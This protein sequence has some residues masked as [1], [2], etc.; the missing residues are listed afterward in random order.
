MYQPNTDFPFRTFMT[1]TQSNVRLPFLPIQQA[2][3]SST[4]RLSVFINTREITIWLTAIS[5]TG[6]CPLR[7]SP[8]AALTC[9]DASNARLYDQTGVSLC[10]LSVIALSVAIR[11][12]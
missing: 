2:N 12:S 10:P 7:G 11:Q 3:L 5:S 6:T 8:E 1:I 4:P 9:Y